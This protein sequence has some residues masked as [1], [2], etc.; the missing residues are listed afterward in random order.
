M[1]DSII[2]I[3]VPGSRSITNRALLIAALARG[4]SKLFGINISDDFESMC[5][6]LNS[7]GFPILID[8][9]K[10]EALV[11]G[12]G[13]FL[14]CNNASVNVGDSGTCARF[15][16]TF[17]GLSNGHFKIESGKQMAGRPMDDLY[18]S[19]EGLGAKIVKTG[20]DAFPIELDGAPLCTPDVTLDITK[21]SQFLSA[22]LI[23]SVKFKDDF[24][25][26]VTGEHGMKYVEM[27]ARIMSHF[28]V[29]F[30]TYNGSYHIPY[31]ARYMARNLYIE[32]DV[33]S[34]CYFYAL[35]MLI[36]R[37]VKVP[38]V[39]SDSIQGDIQFINLLEKMGATITQDSEGLTLIPPASGSFNGIEAK[40]R[41]FSDQ[42]P[43]LAVL[44]IFAS[45]PTTITGVAHIREQESDRIKTVS[46]NL[47][48]L[49]IRNE[50]LPDGIKIY[51]GIPHEC[52]L[53]SF[54]DHRIAMSFGL[55]SAVNP[56]ITLENKD[57][58]RKTFPDFFE[59]LNK[60][61]K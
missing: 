17:L 32:P 56:R 9:D 24:T 34:A 16:T 54:N 20:N 22:L 31:N 2:I 6:C 29:N 36:N 15:I 5:S 11:S 10:K 12:L 51:P 27:T 35:S 48:L 23:S 46:E 33:S 28:G 41:D 13:G 42:V 49:G 43:T 18:A 58:C 53:Q 45:S 60:I 37:P 19:L 8:R 40:M 21:S 4:Q 44:A 25:I 7:L 57:A 47:D 59:I 52:E 50:I 26:H 30:S 1:S 39:Y 14:P 38:G 3:S 55:L 61:V